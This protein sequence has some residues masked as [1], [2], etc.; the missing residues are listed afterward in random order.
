MIEGREKLQADLLDRRRSYEKRLDGFVEG[1]AMEIAAG[2]RHRVYRDRKSE[3][4]VSPL[5]D[6][7]HVARESASYEVRTSMSYAPYV[8]FGT[9]KMAARP[10]LTPATEEVKV[11][12][13]LSPELFGGGT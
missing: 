13:A 9:S 2:A 8:E 6:S 12:F 3:S 1:L 4:P 5:A 7:I 11:R 10:F